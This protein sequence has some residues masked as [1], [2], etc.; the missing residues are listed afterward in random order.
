[1]V[2]LRRQKPQWAAERSAIP[3]IPLNRENNGTNLVWRSGM[4]NWKHWRDL[5]REPDVAALFSFEPGQQIVVCENCG[6]P[7]PLNEVI[8]MK[9]AISAC[10]VSRNSSNA[11][12]KA[13]PCRESGSTLTTLPA[14]SFSRINDLSIS[15]CLDRGFH[16]MKEKFLADGGRDFY[17]YGN[18]RDIQYR[19]S[20]S[21]V[22]RRCCW[23]HCKRSFDRWF[24]FLF[25]N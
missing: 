10:S 23:F 9:T 15:K 13:P 22:C 6:K 11:L 7:F 2:L 17:L 14:R 5:R 21:A 25:I 18:L 4:V 16:L 20:I 12:R 24:V 1:L 8:F 3:G 19:G